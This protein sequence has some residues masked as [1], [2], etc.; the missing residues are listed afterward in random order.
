LG[1][2]PLG[3]YTLAASREGFGEVRFTGIRL[4]VG[5]TRD[6]DVTLGVAQ[7]S[8]NVVVA[9]QLGEIDQASAAVGTG[10]QREQMAELPLNGRNWA[11]C[12][13]S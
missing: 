7:R 2:L 6:I 4:A 12:C 8:E 5:Q 10:I 13:R 1:G 11:S 9:S 3:D